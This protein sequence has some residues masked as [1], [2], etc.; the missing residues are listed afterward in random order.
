VL[1][2]GAEEEQML[3]RVVRHGA[4]LETTDVCPCRFVS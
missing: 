4:K 3:V 2:V 1:P